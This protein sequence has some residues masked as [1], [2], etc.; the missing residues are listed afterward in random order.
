[1]IVKADIVRFYPSVYTHSIPWAIH[2][3][4]F[5]KKNRSRQHFG[6][7]LDFLVRNCQEGQTNG[8]PVGPDTSLLIAELL[9]AIVDKALVRNNSTGIRYMED[10]ELICETEHQSIEARSQLQEEL[11]SLELDLST[12]KTSILALPQQLE[13]S[14]V[15]ALSLFELE[16]NSSYF[17]RQLIR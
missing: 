15:S 2:G 3:K 13:D 7:E 16:E 9:L 10:Y 14:S 8:I 5:A 1:F 17:G 6:N 11:L 12:T 4:A